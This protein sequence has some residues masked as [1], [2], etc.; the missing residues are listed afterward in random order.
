MAARPGSTPPRPPPA[1]RLDR[2]L[3]VARF[4]RSRAAAAEA[5]AAGR[6]RLN[7]RRIDRPARQLAPGDTLTLVHAGRVRLVRVLALAP[8]RGPPA[9]AAALWRDLEAPDPPQPPV[10]E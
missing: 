6:V 4:F 3:F 2:W 10:L 8:R 1:D 9:A 7:G 5:V